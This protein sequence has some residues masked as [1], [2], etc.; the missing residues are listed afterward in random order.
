MKKT[1]F[2]LL[3]LLLVSPAY[4]QTRRPTPTPTPSVDPPITTERLKKLVEHTLKLGVEQEMGPRTGA[5][6]GLTEPGVPFMSK[7]L[8]Y[9]TDGDYTTHVFAVPT[10][11]SGNI[12]IFQFGNNRSQ[13]KA[14][15][16]VLMWVCNLQGKLLSAG[17]VE[18]GKFFLLTVDEAAKSFE[19]EMRGWAEFDINAPQKAQP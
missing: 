13:V 11:N 4:A 10:G 8:I 14:Q 5:P 7:Q 9:E 6:L 17:K 12:V 16:T 3:A 19:T 1:L 18:K 15:Q 2:C